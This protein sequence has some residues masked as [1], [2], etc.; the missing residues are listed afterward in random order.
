LFFVVVRRQTALLAL[1]AVEYKLKTG[2]RRAVGSDFA[3]SQPPKHPSFSWT[4]DSSQLRAMST[5]G[6]GSPDS[7]PSGDGRDATRQ[8]PVSHDIED[9]EEN[10]N[11]D[12]DTNSIPRCSTPQGLSQS[13]GEITISDRQSQHATRPPD[14]EPTLKTTEIFVRGFDPPSTVQDRDREELRGRIG[15][16]L[17]QMTSSHACFKWHDGMV[18]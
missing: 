6:H 10:F 9:K 14:I 15:F 18:T 7:P 4:S 5:Q 8:E 16:S 13:L 3:S 11:E 17:H 1:E 2:C 12:D